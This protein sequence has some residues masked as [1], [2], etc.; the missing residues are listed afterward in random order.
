MS[1]HF[2]PGCE[3]LEREGRSHVLR[4][5]AHSDGKLRAGPLGRQSAAISRSTQSSAGPSL[6]VVPSAIVA[7]R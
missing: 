3:D 1:V 4:P 5:F 7:L 2:G 6:G